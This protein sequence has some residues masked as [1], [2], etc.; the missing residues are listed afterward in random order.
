[1]APTV[2]E[3]LKASGLSDEQIKALDAKIVSGFTTVLTT[4]TTAQQQAAQAKEDADRTLRA[5]KEMLE[6]EINPALDTWATEKANLEAQTAFYRTQ[7]EQAR[8]SGFIPKEAPGFTPPAAD[9]AVSRGTDGR[10]VAGNNPVPGS[11]QFVSVEEANKR[12]YQGLNETTWAMNKHLALFGKP[13]PDELSTL[14][15][16]AS[17][18]HMEFRPYVD[19]KYNF[20]AKE[21]EMQEKAQKDHDDAIVKATEQRLNKEFAER[22]GNNPAL[23]GAEASQFST[24]KQAV[25][26][27]QAKDPLTMS[28]SERHLQTRNL[29]AKDIAERQ[30]A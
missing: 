29:I 9:A 25:A 5:Q 6:K 14:L 8:A 30:S 2:E 1:M 12:L 3:I 13:M 24:V 4:A 11:P 18:Q 15:K 26:A 22:G 27:G 7:N 10:Y 28:A 20:S 16:E 17:E 23:R 21:K 19:R